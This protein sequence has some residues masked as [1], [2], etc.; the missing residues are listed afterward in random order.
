[1]FSWGPAMDIHE[2][3]DQM[4]SVVKLKVASWMPTS[5]ICQM[6]QMKFNMVVP[7]WGTRNKLSHSS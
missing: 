4:L 7:F 5:E 6:S 3:I 2:V 1:M